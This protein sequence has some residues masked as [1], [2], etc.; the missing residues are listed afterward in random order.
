MINL[1]VHGQGVFIFNSNSSC[2][3]SILSC[4]KHGL[5]VMFYEG[6]V[7]VTT[8]DAKNTYVD[9]NNNTYDAFYIMIHTFCR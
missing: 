3:F 2:S 6:G 7:K 1:L 9:D 4:E 8:I 5:I